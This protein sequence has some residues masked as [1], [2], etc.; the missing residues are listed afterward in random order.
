MEEA[1]PVIMI[2]EK[3]RRKQRMDEDM[4][5]LNYSFHAQGILKFSLSFLPLKNRK[6]TI[7]IKQKNAQGA[8]LEERRRSRRNLESMQT[9]AHA[10]L[11]LLHRKGNSILSPS[12]LRPSFSNQTKK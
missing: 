5:K 1:F 11:C 4:A 6:Q 12:F 10:L 7:C 8:G 2:D 3:Q 9:K